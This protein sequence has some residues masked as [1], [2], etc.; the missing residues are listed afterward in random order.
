MPRTVTVGVDGSPESLAAADW[1]A[2]EAEL[3]SRPVRL[4]HAGSWQPFGATAG[5]DGTRAA[6]PEAEA[7]RRRWTQQVL[8]ETAERLTTHRPGLRV[9]FEQVREVPAPA[10]LEAASHGCPLVLGSRTVASA[11]GYEDV[12]TVGP[13]ALS[14]VARARGPVVLVRA[15]T[16]PEDER[17]DG[18]VG[19]SWAGAWH[20]DVVLGLDPAR[21]AAGAVAF[22][23]GEAA[24]RRARLKV[25]HAWR[26]PP[27]VDPEQ[28]R[29][30]DEEAR[31]A[32]REVLAPWR[33]RHPAVR[34]TARTG[35]GAVAARLVDEAAETALLVVG[36]GGADGRIGGVTRTVLRH[37]AVPVAVVP[38]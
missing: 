33:E 31:Q 9:S 24:R 22:A 16:S 2:R 19:P 38:R 20:R 29:V 25:V 15:G 37:C 10:L 8:R 36:R 26:R 11:D 7:A 32:L 30:L 3:W 27:G 18:A 12:W 28:D 34:V 13:V 1:A 6:D 23:F 14:V 4:V 5:G 17:A 21:A 35:F